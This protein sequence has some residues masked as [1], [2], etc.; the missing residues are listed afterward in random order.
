MQ[1]FKTYDGN[2]RL[3]YRPVDNVALVT[4]YEYQYSTINTTPDAISG[5]GDVPV[6][7]DEQPD[8]RPERHLDT[9]VPVEPARLD[10]T[11]S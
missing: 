11:M 9:L 6:V 5:L 3:T 1:S 4:R 10:L 7:H 8:H 2:V